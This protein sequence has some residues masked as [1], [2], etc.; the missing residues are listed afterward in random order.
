MTNQINHLY[1]N[2]I[3]ALMRL[4]FEDGSF[5]AETPNEVR[6][7]EYMEL[8]HTPIKCDIDRSN[9][10][11]DT[12]APTQGP[13]PE[14][15][16]MIDEDGKLKLV[17][18]RGP[19]LMER[20]DA[21]LER[22]T[23][24]EEE[25][26]NAL[27]AVTGLQ[28]QVGALPGRGFLTGD[29]EAIIQ[30]PVKLYIDPVTGASTPIEESIDRI[31][32]ETAWLIE[33]DGKGLGLAG[34]QMRLTWLPFTSPYVTRFARKRDGFRLLEYISL[35]NLIVVHGAEVTEHQWIGEVVHAE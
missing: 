23:Q 4:I 10:E 1:D 21:H 27:F 34:E 26:Q 15:P 28:E 35:N 13:G 32:A 33:K 6:L 11:P 22:I 14:G 3:I 29:M 2:D 9:A 25:M 19:Q 16:Y 5:I 12:N 30:P 17:S 20:L 31:N 18:M 8:R 7:C 24:L